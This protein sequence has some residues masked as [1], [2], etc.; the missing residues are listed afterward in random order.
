[1]DK[2]WLASYPPGIRTDIS[3][4]RP[5]SLKALLEHSCMRFASRPAFTHMGTSIS[6]AELDRLTRHFG[7]FLQ[8]ELGLSKGDRLAVMLPNCLQ[9]P[10]AVM[11]ALRAGLVV[12]NVNPMAT[13][14]ELT[15]Q[16]LNANA[17]AIV[18]LENF[19]TTV[20][21]SL[22]NTE[23]RH[24]VV[25]QLGDLLPMPKG[26]V[27][28]TVVKHIRHL[29]PEW[30]IPTAWH[31]RDAMTIGH[32]SVLADIDVLSS[33]LAFLQYTGGTTGRPK[34]AMLSHGNLVANVEQ[35]IAWLGN[36][37]IDGEETIVTALPLYHVF[38]LTANLLTFLRLGGNNVLISDP[39]DMKQLIST[40]K[41]TRFSVISGVNT[42][43]ANMLAAPEFDEVCRHNAGALK[44]AV[45]GG[46]ALERRVAERWQQAFGKPLLQGYGLTE[47]S[48]IVCADR[49]DSTGFTGK[50]GLPLPSTEVAI[51]DE[52]G[53]PAPLGAAGEI[54]VRGP[55]VM[56]G[57]WRAPA[58]TAQAFTLDGWLRTGDVGRMDP[59]GYVEFVERRKD[60]IVV[61]GFKAFPTEIE[62]VVKEHPL[63][64]DAGVVGVPDARTGEAVALFVVPRDGTLT[65]EMLRAHCTERLSAYKRPSTIE[66][67]SELPRTAIGKVLRR[68]LKEEAIAAV[69]AR[70]IA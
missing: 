9:Q 11:G 8:H 1:M 21:K 18:V 48:P 47:A 39:R 53:Q 38:A 28:N 69:H 29:V 33:D 62:E 60:V 4:D 35:V 32:H 2:I 25:S 63:V 22:P 6:F 55:Q 61:S 40:L 70:A 57:Y 49:V 54:C 42:L 23:V 24:V 15:Q 5:T 43:Y 26:W 16:L 65:L 46:M 56:S 68:Q 7:A 34:A 36:R 19:A 31:W 37:L 51:R 17:S 41:H 12:V 66:L 67:R 10:V 30:S 44:V 45:A 27:V 3:A 13:A 14:S 52:A 58:E 64:K 20:A 50:L 59:N